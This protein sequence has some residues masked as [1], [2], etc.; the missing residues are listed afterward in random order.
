MKP[1]L[2]GTLESD[3]DVRGHGSQAAPGA[4]AEDEAYW[5]SVREA[6]TV[7]EDFIQLEY[8]WYHP[9]AKRVLAAGDTLPLEAQLPAKLA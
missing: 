6:Y 8:G 4:R 1:S 3:L 5:R 2:P 7:P 9:G